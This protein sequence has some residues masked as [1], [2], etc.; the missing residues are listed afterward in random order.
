MAVCG[1]EVDLNEGDEGGRVGYGV[2]V[3]DTE[4]D[5]D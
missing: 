5:G 1:I 4:T 2:D 3:S